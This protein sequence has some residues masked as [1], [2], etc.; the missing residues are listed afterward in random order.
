[1]H[2]RGKGIGCFRKK[3]IKFPPFWDLRGGGA[4]YV[5]GVRKSSV[6]CGFQTL[7]SLFNGEFFT[8]EEKGLMVSVKRGEIFQLFGIS[9]EQE[10][11]FELGF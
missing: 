11:F 1:M 9:E 6:V 7:I 2:R 8:G 5:V 3:G 10:L 4:L